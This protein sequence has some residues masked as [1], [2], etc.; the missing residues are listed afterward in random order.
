MIRRMQVTQ[1]V[2]SVTR[3]LSLAT[4]L[5]IVIVALV[6]F[7]AG[8]V[9]FLGYRRTVAVAA[10]R[11]VARLDTHARALA[12]DLA[13]IMR[14]ARADV[15]GFRFGVGLVDIIA[16]K[17]APPIDGWSFSEWRDRVATRYK[18]ELEAK[19]DYGRFQVIGIAD[20]GL[21]LIRVQR[22]DDGIVRI[23]ADAELQRT[24]RAAFE[25]ALAAGNGGS[26]LSTTDL[27]AG[28]GGITAPPSVLASAPLF[29]AAGAP[30]GVLT[31][32]IG[33]REIFQ[34]FSGVTGFNTRIFLVNDRGD[35][36]IGPDTTRIAGVPW[37]IQDDLPALQSSITTGGK[38]PELVA[39]RNGKRFFIGIAPVRLGDGP[40]LA[41][42]EIVAETTALADPTAAVWNSS[43]IGGA[44]AVLC[45]VLMAVAF[46]RSLVRPLTEM[47][48]AVAGFSQHAPLRGPL[49]ARGEIG[50][51]ARAFTKMAGE[52]REKTAAIQHD[53]EVF[54]SIMATMAESVLVIDMSG[55]LIYQNSAADGI[56]GTPLDRN[57]GN[58]SG[59]FD[60]Y[61]AD[62]VTP[63]PRDAWPSSRCLRGESI[64]EC[65]MQFRLRSADALKYLLCSA[66][67][68]RDAAGV[69]TGAVL[70]TRDVTAVKQTERQL[71]QS[72]KLDAIG[73]LTGGV[74]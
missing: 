6:I 23:V 47:T 42:V 62:G 14:N 35:Y 27:A 67:P 39:D 63:L 48:A 32:S 54:E 57:G 69:Q 18:A 33:L 41:V 44:I 71:Q 52:V 46:A 58:W 13:S 50:V 70:V 49:Q 51:L 36:L 9:G 56:V 73:Q 12:A 7:T 34:R 16:K 11:T 31:I 65:E 5:T 72:Q 38:H 74:A 61:H 60:V 20:Q 24:D 10:Q 64:D 21:E 25:P 29:T 45:A 66:R 40:R 37:R 53:Q 1:E 26:I 43:L 3:E 17:S 8:T 22:D 28:R 15:R 19:P 4:R 59:D 30:F 2:R 55:D 68:I